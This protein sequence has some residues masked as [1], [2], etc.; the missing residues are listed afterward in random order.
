MIRLYSEA[1]VMKFPVKEFI[2]KKL[3][4]L[5]QLYETDSLKQHGEIIIAENEADAVFFEGLYAEFTEKIICEKSIVWHATFP[6][7][8][9]SCKEV[10][11][12]ECFMSNSLKQEWEDN[13]MRTVYEDEFQ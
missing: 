9:S 7:S 12:D 13:L 2:Q 4:L 10:Y 6:T 5:L 3:L 8:N 11:I 1:D